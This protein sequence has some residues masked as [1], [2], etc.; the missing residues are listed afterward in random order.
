MVIF[1]SK[2]LH[3]Q[4][5]YIFLALIFRCRHDLAAGPMGPQV[6]RTYG[7]TWRPV[8][9]PRGQGAVDGSEITS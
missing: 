9:A 3:Q 4:M 8:G 7:E 1:Y 2:P 6:P 5:V